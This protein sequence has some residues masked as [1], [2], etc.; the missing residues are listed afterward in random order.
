M[1]P[2]QKPTKFQATTLGGP[3]K[4]R[5]A[6]VLA[7]LSQVES[8]SFWER[9]PKIGLIVCCIRRDDAPTYPYAATSQINFA[10]MRSKQL[11]HRDFMDA[12]PSVSAHLESGNDALVHCR[13]SFHRAP[14]CTAAFMQTLCGVHYQVPR[15]PANGH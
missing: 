1:A 8:E 5:G 7:D 12:V 13:E 10:D 14:I 3:P 2:L 6:F 11:R 4:L 15:R 9:Y